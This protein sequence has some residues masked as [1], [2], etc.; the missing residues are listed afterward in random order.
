MTNAMKSL[1]SI[2]VVAAG[3]TTSASNAQPLDETKSRGPVLIEFDG[4]NQLSRAAVRE[5]MLRQ[6]LG[7][8]LTVDET[9]RPTKCELHTDFRLKITRISMC[10]P[11]LKYH[12]FEPAL[13]RYGNATVGSYTSEIQLN[14]A[15]KPRDFRSP[16]QDD[17]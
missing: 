17:D 11:L 2:L 1:A 16:D 5:R 9:G 13:D 14:M 8:T 12:R 6:T 15:L 3:F 4:W 10:R 7:F